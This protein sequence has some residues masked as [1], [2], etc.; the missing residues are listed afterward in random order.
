MLNRRP[1]NVT[2]NMAKKL[3]NRSFEYETKYVIPNNN[4]YQVIK[5][6]R[7]TCEKDA[8]YPEGTVSSIYYDTKDWKFISEKI[9]SD[10]LKTKIRIRWYSDIDNEIQY[11][12]SFAEI[13][14]KIGSQREK[15]RIKTPFSG[16]LLNTI[17]LENSMLLQIPGLLRGKGVHI[18]RNLHPIFHIRYKRLRFIDMYSGSRICLDYDISAP[19]VNGYM[20]PRMNPFKLNLTVFEVKGN[21]QNL[22]VSLKPLILFGCIKE[23][24][25]KYQACYGK[26]MQIA[27]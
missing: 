1:D 3:T 12:D 23:S 11:D 14:Y 6:L 8:T 7:S 17:D 16:K 13:K 5:W 25:S 2:V 18:R 21:I 9:N 15:V 22:P 26:I 27:F 24:F 4:A 10:F 20:I 19:R